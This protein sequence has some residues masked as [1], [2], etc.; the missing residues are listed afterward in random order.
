MRKNVLPA[1]SS[2]KIIKIK[3]VFPE[4]YDHRCTAT[5]FMNH[6][7]CIIF[8]L[9]SLIACDVV[10]FD[11]RCERCVCCSLCCLISLFVCPV[12]SG[13]WCITSFHICGK[14]CRGSAAL[15]HCCGVTNV[16][17]LK[18]KVCDVSFM[19]FVCSAFRDVLLN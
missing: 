8:C 16:D 14:K 12:G 15:I 6:S 19:A 9:M 3:R 2:A 18:L 11:S 5:F 1:Y 13:F 17:S 4:L 7:V 10:M